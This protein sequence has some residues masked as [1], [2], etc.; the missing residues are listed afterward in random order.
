MKTNLIALYREEVS[1]LFTQ[2]KDSPYLNSFK[3]GIRE[4]CKEIDVG[5]PKDHEKYEEEFL[6]KKNKLKGDMFE[7][8]A[9]MFF[10][11]FNADGRVGIHDYVPTDSEKDF[12]V[13]GWGYNVLNNKCVVQ[14]KYR[15]KEND[16][17]EYGDIAKCFTSGIIDY[18]INQDHDYTVFLL[19]TSD[20]NY[21]LKDR[22]KNRLQTIN[23]KFI[24]ELV[25]GNEWFWELCFNMIEIV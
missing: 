8:F 3:D 20:S 23:G 18:K 13:D 22:F 7:I 1:N 19:T 10:T 17:I 2:T 5:L 11:I 15:S 4:L 16:L 21:I 6:K 12:G 14:V 25:D 24:R 9:E